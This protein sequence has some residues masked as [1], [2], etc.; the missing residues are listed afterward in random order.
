MGGKKQLT[1]AD[2]IARAREAHGERYDY[3]Q[4]SY[5]ASTKKLTIICPEHGPF[6]QLPLHHVKGKGGC[7]ICA[8]VSRAGLKKEAAATSFIAR[9][10]EIHGDRYNY[11]QTEYDGCKQ[12]LKIICHTHGLFEQGAGDHLRGSNCP[13]CVGKGR[14]TNDTFAISA[15]A[16]HGDKYDYSKVNYIKS[17]AKVKIICPEHGAFEQAA[18]GHLQ[19]TGCHKCGG[20]SRLSDTEFIQKAR[21]VHGNRYDYSQTVYGEN[22]RKKISIICPTHGVFKQQ[23]N[24]HLNGFGCREC[25]G[26]APLA[27]A[28]F[29]VRA[30]EIHGGRYDYSQTV[31][32]RSSQ[33]VK[34][35]C[36]EHGAFK[37]NPHD[38]LKY[39]C[40]LCGYRVA[41][42]RQAHTVASFLARALEV[43][44]NRYDYSQTVYGENGRKKISIIC[45]TH[46]VFKQQ[47]NSH[48]RGVGCPSC[49]FERTR[50]SWV[51][52]ASGRSA[53]LYFLRIYQLQEVFY[54]VGITYRTV[55]DR[56]AGLLS[57]TGYQYEILA[58]HQSDA[59]RVWDWEQSIL[60]TFAHLSHKPKVY[61]EGQSEC[62]SNCEEILAIFP[63]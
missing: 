11:S 63:L 24:S 7:A 49:G 51:R 15:K 25:G 60:D 8:V 17:S 4:S 5:L 28:T 37:Q 61:F 35:I 12:K 41:A 50:L 16:I 19:G 30:R 40:N 54:K 57:T 58:L 43:H 14:Y 31:Y 53:T 45:P 48:L 59:A 38:H 52:Q 36:P 1:T 55:K 56:F 23:A 21:Q 13:W 42:E 34:I 22:G 33:K 26:T 44:G 9:A 20:T 2:F 47:A 32:A 10:R 6:E 3:S 62:F 18:T 46:G 39:G 27:T 29:L